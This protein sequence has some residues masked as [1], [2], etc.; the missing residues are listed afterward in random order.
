MLA[1]HAHIYRYQHTKVLSLRTL[2]EHFISHVIK[3]NIF[4]E[5]GK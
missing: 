3:K 5:F 1:S 2:L 4:L